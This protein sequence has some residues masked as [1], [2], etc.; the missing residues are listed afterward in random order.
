MRPLHIFPPLRIVGDVVVV[1]IVVVV[2]VVA[3]ML[4][5]R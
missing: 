1:V 4:Y 2:I 3:S 5:D